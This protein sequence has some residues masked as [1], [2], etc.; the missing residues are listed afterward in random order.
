MVNSYWCFLHGCSKGNWSHWYHIFGSLNSWA[1][2]LSSPKCYAH[3]RPFCHPSLFQQLQ[4]LP[5]WNRDGGNHLSQAKPK[6]ISW[7]C[8][9]YHS[10]PLNC[11]FSCMCVSNFQILPV[12]G[13]PQLRFDKF[14]SYLRIFIASL[15]KQAQL[16]LRLA[17]GGLSSSLFIW[18]VGKDFD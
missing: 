17:L 2:F 16:R 3:Y 1:W 14:K 13:G 18:W 11:W 5:S 7:G 15:K 8:L 9:Y 6:A 4:K 10:V 12:V